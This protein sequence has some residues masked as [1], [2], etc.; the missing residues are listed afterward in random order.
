MATVSA[1]IASVLLIYG[2][3][4]VQGSGDPLLLIQSQAKASKSM[5]CHIVSRDPNRDNT[6]I[7]CIYK[8]PNG[9]T[10]AEVIPKGS[11]CP[12]Y[13]NVPQ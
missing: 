13:I 3:S 7:K 10:E 6:R 8:C 11:S 1:A 12:A 2:G 9:K 5:N 4:T